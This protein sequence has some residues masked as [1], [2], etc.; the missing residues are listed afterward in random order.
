[1]AEEAPARERARLAALTALLLAFFVGLFVVRG[2]R[3]PVGPDGPVYLW[4]TRLAG[5]EG[6]STV[7]RPGVPAV[8]LSLSATLHLD[9][10]AVA[11]GLQSALGVAVGLA[12]AALLRQW[13]PDDRPA[14][15]LG[16]ALTGLFAAHLVSG[17]LAN[18]ALAAAF[19]AAA[20]ALGLPTRRGVAAAALLLA[21][22]AFAHPQFSLVAAA[23][24]AIAAALGWRERRGGWA[25]E[26]GRVALA[27][28]GSAVVAGAGFLWLLAGPPVLRVDTSRDAFLRR[29]GMLE[30]LRSLYRDRFVHRAARYVEW[31]SVPLALVGLPKVRGW[32]GRLL[33]AWGIVTVAGV[34]FGLVTGL[35]PPD[36]FVTFGY[37]VPL[38]AA[39]GAVALWRRLEPRRALATAVVAIAVV[40]MALGTFVAWRRQ[41]PFLTPAQVA[42]VTEAAPGIDGTRPGTPIFVVAETGG[43]SITF[44]ATQAANI[45]RA[46]VPPDRIA[47]VHVLILPSPG[48]GAERAAL[49]RDSF[50][51]YDPASSPVV[52]YL[53]PFEGPLY[54]RATSALA[55]LSPCAQP[56][57]VIDLADGV[58]VGRP[59]VGGE[60]TLG[61]KEADPLEPS[62]PAGIALATLAVLLLLGLG[63]FGWG[64]AA[65]FDAD[66]ALA[67][68]PA[69]GLGALTISSIALDRLG[70][71]I[72]GA[73]GGTAAAA[74][75]TVGGLA[76]WQVG[77]RRVRREPAP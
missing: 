8:I 28:G 17:Y 40:L 63:G 56:S 15:L 36:R 72:G 57:S 42:A 38:L 46:A 12:G 24:L 13:G 39:V 50:R 9:V 4:W 20:C 11:A 68:S 59:C 31:I 26:P 3:F 49:S 58:R 27:I 75:A 51:P 5:A 32:V 2:F 48:A 67:L 41:E 53:R 30:T 74:I 45:V 73:V 21:A 61:L 65:G 22:G 1:V 71:G 44:F 19:L 43:S 47:D 76:A 70:V 14:W 33:V 55:D 18:L 10:V 35:V 62:S 7:E 52:L 66:A 29:V 25:S 64:R 54:G 6:L 69:V 23:I 34:A 16:G 77:E 60:L 37:V